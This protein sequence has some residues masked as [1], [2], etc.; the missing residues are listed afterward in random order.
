MEDNEVGCL[1]PGNDISHTSIGLNT[2][3]GAAISGVIHPPIQ[4]LTEAKPPPGETWTSTT[5]TTTATTTST[6]VTDT[7]ITRTTTITQT[8]TETVT[9]TTLTTGP[10]TTTKR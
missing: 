4:A 8:I 1:I 9:S 6:T 7:T 2:G 10:P 3:G 5:E